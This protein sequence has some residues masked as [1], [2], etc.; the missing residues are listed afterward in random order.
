M[1]NYFPRP[2]AAFLNRYLNQ[3][4][5]QIGL[6]YYYK[7]DKAKHLDDALYWQDVGGK[8]KTQIQFPVTP[9][10]HRRERVLIETMYDRFYSSDRIEQ[11]EIELLLEHWRHMM[12]P[13]ATHWPMLAGLLARAQ[14]FLFG[15]STLRLKYYFNN[16]SYLHMEV[17]GSDTLHIDH[18]L[19][20][21]F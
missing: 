8:I 15:M 17:T 10:V 20:P 7:F 13:D 18:M 19:I 14:D 5:N 4:P 3:S 16:N 2:I 6:K 21:W 1:C 9:G 12:Y 11:K